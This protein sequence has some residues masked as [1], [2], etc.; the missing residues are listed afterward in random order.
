[1][2]SLAKLQSHQKKK[3]MHCPAAKSYI[4]GRKGG[5]GN[6]NKKTK[7]TKIKNKQKTLLADLNYVYKQ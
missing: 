6:I 1:M 7:T 4:M 3:K 2:G 5:R